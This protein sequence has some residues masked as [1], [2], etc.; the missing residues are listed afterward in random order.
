MDKYLSIDKKRRLNLVSGEF[1]IGFF[2]VFNMILTFSLNLIPHCITY[3]VTVLDFQLV[4]D[5]VFVKVHVQMSLQHGLRS[6][7]D[8]FSHLC[9]ICH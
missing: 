1:R 8:F 4:R 7:G 6:V 3:H 9:I 5:T 2:S